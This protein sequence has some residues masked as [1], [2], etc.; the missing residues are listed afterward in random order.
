MG[1]T[2]RFVRV[3]SGASARGQ[4]SWQS[5]IEG[6][7]GAS[8][9]CQRPARRR[10]QFLDWHGRGMKR[11]EARMRP[12]PGGGGGEGARSERSSQ[13]E[14]HIRDYAGINRSAVTSHHIVV[15]SD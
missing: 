6:R 15:V 2:C 7:A 9:G 4:R 3:D 10:S 11:D 1:L 8:S 12:Q 13:A 5:P 14:R